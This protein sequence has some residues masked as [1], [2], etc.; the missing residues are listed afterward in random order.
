M[1]PFFINYNKEPKRVKGLTFQE[2]DH[3]YLFSQNLHLKQPN[4]KLNFKRY[5][6]F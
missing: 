4:K 2:G 6:L 5:R 1:L 3:I